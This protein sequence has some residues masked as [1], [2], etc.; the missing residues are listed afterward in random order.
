MGGQGVGPAERGLAG[1]AQEQEQ[2]P[3]WQARTGQEQAW[4]IQE[5]EWTDAEQEWAAMMWAP[6]EQD[7]ASEGSWAGC[8]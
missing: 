3:A 7:A 4:T 5:Q 1:K 8:G 6:S 2:A